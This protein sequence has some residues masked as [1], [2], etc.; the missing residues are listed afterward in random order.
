MGCLSAAL[1]ECRHGLDERL[2][3]LKRMI[4]EDD[5]G[6][7]ED[8]FP[9]SAGGSFSDDTASDAIGGRVGAPLMKKL[10]LVEQVQCELSNAYDELLEQMVRSRFA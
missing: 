4:A 5:G 10:E 9:S 7:S 2:P 3:N 1:R 8:T 6:L